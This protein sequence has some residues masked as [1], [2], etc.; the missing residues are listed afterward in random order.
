MKMAN[1][2]PGKLLLAFLSVMYRSASRLSASPT[3]GI[4]RLKKNI[5]TSLDIVTHTC[6]PSSWE[7]EAGGSGAQGYSQVHSKFRANLVI[8][9]IISEKKTT[10]NPNDSKTKQQKTIHLVIGTKLLWV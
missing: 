4:V 6:S 9:K 7:E 2:F 8:L 10:T 5:F 1:C 3:F